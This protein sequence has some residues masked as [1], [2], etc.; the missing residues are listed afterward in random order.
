VRTGQRVTALT[1][2]PVKSLAGVALASSPVDARGLRGDRRWGVVDASG[3]KIT[4]REVKA[5]LG[6]RAEPAAAVGP[7]AIRIADRLGRVLEVSPP[8]RARPI[9]VTHSGQPTALPAGSEADAW[10]SERLGR[11][12]RLVWQDDGATRPIRPELGGRP[13]DTNSLSDAAPILVTTEPS[14]DR[15]NVWLAEGGSDPVDHER[16]RPNVVVDGDAPFAEDGWEELRIGT[17]PL[18]R[19]MVCDRCV[20]TT[21]DRAT[22]ATTKE[23]VRTLAR[24]RK[25]DGATWFG[26]RL[27]PLLPMAP[28]AAFTVGD[29]VVVSPVTASGAP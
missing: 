6:L 22:L 4:A 19:T 2:Y 28:D 29:P 8:R 15:L 26:V 11:A 10:L 24:H 14:L 12:V 20:M 1:L 3:A 25:W 16:F 13:G 23:P 27:T 5:L 18:R 9:P 17:V 7:G 21:I